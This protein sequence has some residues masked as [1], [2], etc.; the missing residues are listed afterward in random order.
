MIA[1]CLLQQ[2]VLPVCSSARTDNRPPTPHARTDHP[3]RHGH[4]A[5][6][7]RSRDSREHLPLVARW[8]EAQPARRRQRARD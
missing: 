6:Y 7:Q 3:L 1:V 2:T 5:F 8:Q 4:A